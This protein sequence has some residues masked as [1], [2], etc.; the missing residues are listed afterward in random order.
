MYTC[1]ARHLAVAFGAASL[2]GLSAGASG[3][4]T[5]TGPDITPPPMTGGQRPSVPSA[6]TARSTA[7]G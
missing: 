4:A 5:G 1:F 7:V 2:V 3:Q 6:S